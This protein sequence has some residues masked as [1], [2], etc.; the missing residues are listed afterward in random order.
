MIDSAKY[1]SKQNHSRLFDFAQPS[2]L[3]LWLHILTTLSRWRA[4]YFEV[5]CFRNDLIPP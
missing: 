1:T 3:H 5:L 2:S 4:T